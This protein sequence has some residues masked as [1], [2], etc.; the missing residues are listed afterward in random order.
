M[1]IKLNTSPN[2]P[3]RSSTRKIMLELTI[4]LLATFAFALYYQFSKRGM[5]NAVY[6]LVLMVV[7]IVTAVLCEV[8][9]AIIF[10]RK[11][12]IEYVRDSFPWVT[13]IILVLMIPVN[14]AIYPL[15]IGT[16]VAIVIAKLLFGGFGQNIFNPAAVGCAVIFAYFAT[17]FASDITTGA[18]PT[19]LIA[20]SYGWL[21]GEQ[22]LV[23]GF[24]DKFGGLTNL[25]VGMHDGALGET[26]VLVLLICG[27]YLAV[28]KV[29]DWRIPTFYVGTV[30]VMATI[31]ALATGVGMWYPV[32]HI[33]TGGLMFGAVF[34]A[35]DPV[36][37][38]TS[39]AGKVIFAIG[40]GMLTFL[41]RMKGNLPEGVLYSILIMN[42]LSPAIEHILSGVQFKIAKKAY[43]TFAVTIVATLGIAGWTALTVKPYVSP[44]PVVKEFLNS[45]KPVSISD[46]LSKYPA[47]VTGQVQDGANI[48]FTVEVDGYAVVVSDY[49]DPHSNIIL[50]TINVDTKAVVSV[51]YEKFSDTEHV[52]DSTMDSRF[53][54]QFEG[55][56]ITSSSSSVDTVSGATITSDAIMSAVQVAIAELQ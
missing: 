5:D 40:C 35:T 28:R 21:V 3:D 29:I 12:P 16:I 37:N 17:G 48:T 14:T 36:T 32:F 1:K 7:A 4:A 19:R 13:A 22:G 46:D 9:W 31:V 8:L 15:V 51:A 2:Y 27:I 34:M 39:V 44:P 53:L 24:L 38:P 43:I 45:D 23:D 11:N 6:A 10:V 55:L 42:M 25:F 20:S 52:G 30:F 56:D 26:S 49:P 54:S 41:I 18:T 50:V 33:L 47:V